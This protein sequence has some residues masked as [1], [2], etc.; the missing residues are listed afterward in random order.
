M[1][2]SI[3]TGENIDSIHAMDPVPPYTKDKPFRQAVAM[4]REDPVVNDYLKWEYD[5]EITDTLPGIG[6]GQLKDQDG[7]CL[8][9]TKF[10][11]YVGPSGSQTLVQVVPCIS[12]LDFDG[13]DPDQLSDFTKQV[14]IAVKGDSSD[15]LVYI[16]NI[17][18]GLVLKKISENVVEPVCEHGDDVYD[19]QPHCHFL[20]F[21]VEL[22][23]KSEC[24]HNHKFNINSCLYNFKSV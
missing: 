17:C 19:G 22:V 23:E 3:N 7:N 8:A 11:N 16:Q 10:D 20:H 13:L 14:W 18:T 6:G 2:P 9:Y 12:P 4:V 21:D 24:V 15:D 5:T 1:S